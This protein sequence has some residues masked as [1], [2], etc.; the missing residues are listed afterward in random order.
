MLPKASR[1]TEK[2]DFENVRQ[3]GKFIRTNLF[4]VSCL[5][6]NKEESRFGF[7]VS[8]KVSMKAIQRNRI[9]RMLRETVR[10]HVDEI[11]KGMDFVI[12]A[13]SSVVQALRDTLETDLLK[14]L[15]NV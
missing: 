3:K 10:L 1:L 12:V 9:K 6:N 8:K 2:K 15:K 5:I 13:K 11:K 4:T 14:T 7:I